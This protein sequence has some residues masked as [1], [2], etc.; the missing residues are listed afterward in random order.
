MLEA[1]LL[2]VMLACPTL[3]LHSTQRALTRGGVEGNPILGQNPVRRNGIFIG[4]TVGSV[5][6]WK[7]DKKHRNAIAIATAAPH[8]VAATLNYKRF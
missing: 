5:V 3:D 8:C 2:G 6:W 1:I 4:V 7:K